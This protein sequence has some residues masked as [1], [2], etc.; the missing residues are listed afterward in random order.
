[1]FHVQ[2]FDKDNFIN[3]LEESYSEKFVTPY[4]ADMAAK[5]NKDIIT[6]EQD[7]TIEPAQ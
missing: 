1:M 6:Y 7:L 5:L 2:N 3:K 4:I